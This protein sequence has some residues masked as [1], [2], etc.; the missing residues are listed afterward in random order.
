MA[1]NTAKSQGFS[2]F[3]ILVYVL[4]FIPKATIFVFEV[5]DFKN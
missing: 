4:Y 2:L 1:F 5:I 3:S